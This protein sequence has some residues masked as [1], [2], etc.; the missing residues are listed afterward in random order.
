MG[1]IAPLPPNILADQETISQPGGRLC[2]PHYNNPS[3]MVV[4]AFIV[5]SFYYWSGLTVY[6]SMSYSDDLFKAFIV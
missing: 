4:P 3:G 1:A 2:P 5:F 6:T